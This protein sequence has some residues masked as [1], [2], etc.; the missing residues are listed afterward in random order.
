MQAEF[1]HVL[2]I[3]GVPVAVYDADA[4]TMLAMEILDLP[5]DC[6][7]G[8]ATVPFGEL[9]ELGRELRQCASD[10]AAGADD[11]RAALPC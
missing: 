5:E 4:Y 8:I 9:S 10:R 7:A 3:R 11:A 2:T 6:E 1:C